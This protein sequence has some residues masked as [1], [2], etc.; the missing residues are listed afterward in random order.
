MD[1]EVT[2]DLLKTLESSL[3]ELRSLVT[4][5]ICL[6][7]LYE[8]YTIAC[9]H[10]FC[11][12]CLS[13]WFVSSKARKTCP[14]CRHRVTHQPAPAYMVSLSKLMWISADNSGQVREMTQ[15]FI[16]RVELLPGGETT[17]DHKKW[18]REEMELVERDKSNDDR[19]VG[20]L[21]RGSFKP[22][23]LNRRAIRDDEDGVERCP[24]CMWEL[25]D[26]LCIRCH[27]GLDS[28]GVMAEDFSDL[29][30]R[31]STS[32]YDG[33][34]EEMDL[35]ID[36]E[37]R[38]ADIDPDLWTQDDSD[39]SLDGN[40]RPIHTVREF[41]EGGWGI[42]RRGARNG[43]GHARAAGVSR[44]GEAVDWEH[45]G[46]PWPSDGALSDSDDEEQE[47]EQD[48]EAGSLD[49]FVVDED[50]TAASRSQRSPGSEPS[51]IS[52]IAY[53]GRGGDLNS[54]DSN[55]SSH[56]LTAQQWD[57]EDSDEGGGV[58]NGR[59]R[60]RSGRIRAHR[61]NGIQR[62]PGGF[63]IPHT[64]DNEADSD[65]AA[66]TLL[67]A[68]WAQLDQDEHEEN[69]HGLDIIN[70][71]AGVRSTVDMS[72][73][74]A[75]NATLTPRH[76]HRHRFHFSGERL[77]RLHRGETVSVRSTSTPQPSSGGSRQV[78][79]SA[80]STI[81]FVRRATAPHSRRRRE[82]TVA[83]TSVDTSDACNMV[84]EDES[85]SDRD[86]SYL[87]Q[88]S[89]LASS[90]NASAVASRA[91]SRDPS[92]D[93][94]HDWQQHP[95]D[96]SESSGYET[97]S[98]NSPHLGHRV[99][100]ETATATVGG[101]SSV[102]NSATAIRPSTTRM[103][104]QSPIYINSSPVKSDA[105]P[106]SADQASESQQSESP[107][108]NHNTHRRRQ[109]SPRSDLIRHRN[110]QGRPR[111]Q[112]SATNFRAS[113]AR[114]ELQNRLSRPHIRGGGDLFTG[115]SHSRYARQPTQSP[116]E[117]EREQAAAEKAANKA[118]RRRA[119]NLWRQQQRQQRQQW[120]HNPFLSAQRRLS[121]PGWVP[122]EAAERYPNLHGHP[123]PSNWVED[124]YPR[125][126]EALWGFDEAID[127]DDEMW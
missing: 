88:F 113:N 17:S 125:G 4:C 67:Q 39:I 25:E 46:Q 99:S 81:D 72:R 90:S 107:I 8:P 127:R 16:G 75:G 121:R 98:G 38:A 36:M 122:H 30:D 103:A 2:G 69:N 78:P 1:S 55:R 95:S 43:G 84:S 83:S 76:A 108:S 119:K 34:D 57:E 28:D 61:R 54:I 40:G 13:Q 11:Y 10:T 80:P 73:A 126:S 110:P 59:R 79:E 96:G 23:F 53:E 66:D 74:V 26:G 114:L 15:V 48:D 21:F 65:E 93:R 29:D 71:P 24:R 44:M 92:G 91:S 56:E 5:R 50:E 22:P 51:T 111:G 89:P 20:G 49:D 64:S 82:L 123:A 12:G 52:H 94:V 87:E 47:A 37:E 6:R 7:L 115:A 35:E 77:A 70:G 9:G 19:T 112:P 32:T 41:P 100:S 18:Q 105:T 102:V 68:G 104:P 62:A 14:D 33:T 3:D 101:S 60:M 86:L 27:V 120:Q 116:E 109:I 63:P 45:G 58:S 31:L 106:S 117:R 118:E 124:F 85:L 97:P 42:E